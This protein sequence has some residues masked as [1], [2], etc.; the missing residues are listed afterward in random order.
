[1]R[2]G[3]LAAPLNTDQWALAGQPASGSPRAR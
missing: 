1:L 2:S 3:N